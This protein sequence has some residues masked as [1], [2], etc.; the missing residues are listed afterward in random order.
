MKNIKKKLTKA[1]SKKA[2]RSNGRVSVRHQGGGEKRR[3][4]EVDWKR[5]KFD[6]AG[7]VEAIE[8]A[9]SRSANVALI[10]YQDGERRYI[11]ATK[12]MKPGFAVMSGNKAPIKEGT[13]TTLERIP[14]G[15]PIHSIELKPGKGGQLVRGAGTMATISAKEGGVA[16]VRLPSKELRK[17]SLS[18]RATIGQVGNEAHGLRKM[19]KAGQK[20]HKGIRP[21]VRGVAQH[22]G[23]HPHGGGEGR[24]G[25]GM[26]S[27][28]TPWGKKTLGKKTRRRKKYSDKNILIRRLTKAQK[29]NKQ[30]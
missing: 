7:K 16:H 10:L 20:R 25:I 26:P 27:P 1:V 29:K 30:K 5:D 19:T 24:S 14:L 12:N 15:M 9:P 3:V 18:C 28:K 22:P 13:S 21:T 4:R 6:V 8:Y 2:G 23:S 17:I 11:L